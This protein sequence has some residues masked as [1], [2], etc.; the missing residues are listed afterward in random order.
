AT[1]TS[2]VVRRPSTA[3]AVGDGSLVIG[4]TPLGVAA[5]ELFMAVENMAAAASWGPGNPLTKVVAL[6]DDPGWTARTESFTRPDNNRVSRRLRGIWETASIAAAQD[7]NHYTISFATY[8]LPPHPQSAAV[9]PVNWFRGAVRVPVAG[10]DPEDRR[11]LR[12]LHIGARPGGAELELLAVDDS[13]E[14]G[15][16]AVGS[17][18][19]VNYFPG[20]MVHLHADPVRG[21]DRAA[22]MPSAGEGNRTTLLGLR[23][24]DPTTLDGSGKPYR[25][26]VGVPQLLT[27]AEI[28][29]PGVPRKPKGLKYATPPD[30]YGKSSFTLTVEFDSA[31]FAVAFYRA[32]AFAIL[33]ALYEPAEQALIRSSIFPPGSDPYFANRFDDLFA[34]LDP[35]DPSPVPTAS[36]IAGGGSYAL[37]VPNAASLGLG[38]LALLADRKARM[39][40]A[41]LEAFV[42]LTEQPLIYELISTDP[43]YAPTN[44]RQNFR[45]DKGEIIAPGS[46]GFDLS[47]MAKRPGGDAIQFTDFTLEGSMNRD[48]VYFYMARELGNRMQL[49]DP[50]PVFGPVKLVNLTPPAAPKVRKIESVPYNRVTEHG[51]EVRFELLPPSGSDPVARL[52]LYRAGSAVDALS[53]RT[54]RMVKDLPL[55]ALAVSADRTLLAADDFADE[56]FVPFGDPLYYRLAWVR[57]VDY[58]DASA[59]PQM[60]E[61]LSDPSETLLVNLVD[62]VNPEAPRPAVALL[63]TDASTGDKLIELRWPKTTHN[64]IYYVAQLGP[65]GSWFRLATLKTNALQPSFALP[66]PLPI[67]DADGETIHYRF[68]IDVEN[69]SGLLNLLDAPVTMHLADL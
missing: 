9:D 38:G 63:A 53:V 15:A 54:M 32:D 8:V 68:K 39:R 36:P 64:G 44:A 37:P 10:R 62:V 25:S 11:M 3:G 16:V 48:T 12:V 21:F 28:L 30:A 26:L 40:E 5:G 66:T 45:N 58:E 35:A 51:P 18:R 65:S 34:F 55:S 50:S 41:L 1:T 47:P 59:V 60:A 52:R 67:S 19:L 13:G 24:V 23:S 27:A 29:E 56:P 31:P 57:E 43:T 2:A 61:A 42:A 17:G 7:A 49:G 14:Q 46:A 6:G 22:L 4:N 69:S 20:Y 33:E